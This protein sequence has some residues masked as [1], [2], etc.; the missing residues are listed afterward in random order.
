[1]NSFPILTLLIVLPVVGAV[2]ALFAGRHARAVAM[3]AALAA[4]S[5]ALIVWTRLP[6]DGT[7]GLVE[8]RA[9]APSLDIEYHLG[10]DGL[11]ARSNQLSTTSPSI[12]SRRGYAR[13]SGLVDHVRPCASTRCMNCWTSDG[14][15][16]L[17]FTIR[18]SSRAGDGCPA[19][20]AAGWP[21]LCMSLPFSGRAIA[22]PK[23]KVWP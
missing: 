13:W 8:Q 18:H 16:A 15:S 3:I 4:M 9:W 20:P 21:L 1:M 2:I 19:T 14:S 6:P 12:H 23:Q 10:V 11:G 7:M 17:A 5:V 22:P